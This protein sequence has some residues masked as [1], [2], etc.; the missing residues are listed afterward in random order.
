MRKEKKTFSKEQEFEQRIVDIARVT[1][2]MAGGK[3]LKFRVTM[4]VGDKK[5]RV[6]IGIAKGADVTIAITKAVNVAK[7]NL[8]ET[9]IVEGTLPCRITE[10]FG[11]ARILLKPAQPGIGIIAGG[12]VRTVLELS[13]LQDAIGKIYGSKNKINNVKA[14]ISAL[15]KLQPFVE[16]KRKI[17]EAQKKRAKEQTTAKP[18]EKTGEKKSVSPNKKQSPKAKNTTQNNKK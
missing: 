5:G 17:L 10:K 4:V 14:T 7:K 9:P 12:A 3:R 11:A 15:K 16:K 8:I 6:G 13:G 1:R 2:V 18:Q